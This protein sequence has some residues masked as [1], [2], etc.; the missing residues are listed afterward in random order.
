[1][2]KTITS[3]VY[4]LGNI[5]KSKIFIGCIDLISVGEEFHHPV[6]DEIMINIFKENIWF[7]YVKISKI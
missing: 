3:D 1:M 6:G 7:A 4:F 5:K 2:P